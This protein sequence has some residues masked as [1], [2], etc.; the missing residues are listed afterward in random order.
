CGRAGRATRT[1]ASTPPQPVEY[2]YVEVDIHHWREPH[3]HSPQARRPDVLR[4][5]R[6]RPVRAASATRTFY[7]VAS[8]TAR[9]LVIV[10]GAAHGTALLASPALARDI[11]TFIQHHDR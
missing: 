3:V 5:R 2:D 7:N 4:E 6:G 1:R 11:T 8:A 10:P 9:Q